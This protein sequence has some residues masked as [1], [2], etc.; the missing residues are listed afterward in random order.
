MADADVC[1]HVTSGSKLDDSQGKMFDG[2]TI[3]PFRN[4]YTIDLFHPEEV[5]F[6]FLV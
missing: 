6:I 5:F 2:M 3:R 1:C 4:L